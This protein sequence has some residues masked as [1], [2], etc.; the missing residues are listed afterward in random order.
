MD[1]TE[2]ALLRLFIAD[3]AGNT[4][5]L[6]DNNLEDLYQANEEDLYATAAD[7]WRMKAGDVAA[8]YTANIDG[9]FLS[10]DQVWQH[11]MAM[12]EHYEKMSGGSLIS[13]TMDS[14]FQTETSAS[15][16]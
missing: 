1:A 16:F 12:A 5:F 7:A 13:V 11:C 6:H 14:G 10:R 4:E 2:L 3:P 15:E 9:A 8:W